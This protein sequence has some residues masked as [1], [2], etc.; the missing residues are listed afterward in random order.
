MEKT[1]ITNMR[2]QPIKFLGFEIKC[3]RGKGRTGYVVRS[4]PDI[5][6]I[7]PKIRQILGEIRDINSYPLEEEKLIQIHN[8]NSMIRGLIEYYKYATRV[9]IVFNKFSK[10]MGWSAFKSLS[11]WRKTQWVRACDSTNLQL[12][13]SEYTEKLASIKVRGEVIAITNINMVRW[14]KIAQ[15]NQ[16]ETPYSKEGRL[17][18][19]MRMKK[20]P[21]KRKSHGT[22]HSP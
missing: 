21:L 3:W 10:M 9:N 4:K 7:R 2:K 11:K 14:T 20:R 22:K 12:V 5:N 16:D 17:K 1:K 13:H 6:R 8:I 18:Y 15:K 19:V